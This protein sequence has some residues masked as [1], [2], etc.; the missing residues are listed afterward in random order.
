MAGTE[1]PTLLAVAACSSSLIIDL[2]S[3]IGLS[4]E[5]L[6]SYTGDV[7][8]TDAISYGLA[9]ARSKGLAPVNVQ[10]LLPCFCRMSTALKQAQ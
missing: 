6:T 2:Y 10:V 4:D 7:L 9:A 1:K 3:A 8:C 5:T